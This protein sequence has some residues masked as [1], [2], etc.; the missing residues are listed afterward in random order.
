MSNSVKTLA[1]MLALAAARA[2]DN[3]FAVV[4]TRNDTKDVTIHFG[5][6][7]T[8]CWI[9]WPGKSPGRPSCRIRRSHR[10]NGCASSSKSRVLSVCRRMSRLLPSLSIVAP[11]Q[12]SDFE[13]TSSRDSMEELEQ[14]RPR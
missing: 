5:Y 12:F 2:D 4:T 6:R 1:A 7:L 8:R 3:R 13:C 11:L 14:K 10:W 9:S